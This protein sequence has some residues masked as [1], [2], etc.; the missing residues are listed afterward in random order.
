MIHCSTHKNDRMKKN[1]CNK[2]KGK[3]LKFLRNIANGFQIN[4]FERNKA[5]L[6]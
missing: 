4:I 1:I 6:F 2:L 3:A 5:T